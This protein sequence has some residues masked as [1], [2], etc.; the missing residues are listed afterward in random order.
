MTANLSV[1]T[2]VDEVE[3][4]IRRHLP[5]IDPPLNHIFTPGLYTREIFLP[6]HSLSVSKIH[7]TEHPF[8]I[9]MGKVAVWDCISQEVTVFSA[10][11]T[12]VTKP[13][14]QRVIFAHEDTVWST[15]HPTDET[16]IERIEA[17]IIE[18]HT[19]P[20]LTDELIA[21]LHSNAD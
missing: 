11:F 21:R 14:T 5:L 18:P 6:K 15:F 8:V 9:S 2:R 10:P 19:N 13:G 12:G 17:T 20:L 16:D 3:A 1:P 4:V 7:R